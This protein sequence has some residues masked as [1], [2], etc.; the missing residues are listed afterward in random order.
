MFNILKSYWLRTKRTPSRMII[1]LCP[2]LFALLLGLYSLSSRYLQG[3][4]MSVFFSA[5]TILA[6]F[7]ISFLIPVL[8]ETDKIA[9]GFANDLRCGI[10]RKKIG[11]ARFLFFSILIL[12][13]EIIALLIVMGLL[14]F[15]GVTFNHIELLF[16]YLMSATAL[17]FMLPIYQ[18]LSLVYGYSGSILAGA[19]FT[20][21]AILLGTTGLGENI[22]KFLPFVWSVKFVF[23]YAKHQFSIYDRLVFSIVSIIC[24]AVNVYIFDKWYNKWEGIS[25]MEE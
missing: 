14:S 6:S 16:Y 20:L 2:I 25:K 12:V 23:A 3:K 17:I 8:Y 18:Y 24:A 4:E 15:K 1:A 10:S 21:S 19:F 13:I 11:F 7:S 5:Y 22:W 9:G